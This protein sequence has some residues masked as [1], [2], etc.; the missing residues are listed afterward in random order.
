MSPT[1]H[2]L[3]ERHRLQKNEAETF[4]CARHGEHVAATICRRERVTRN[5]APEVNAL[6]H[7]QCLRH[8]FETRTVVAVTDDKEREIGDRTLEPGYGLDQ[9]IDALVTIGRDL[10]ANGQE[11]FAIR[12]PIS[13]RRLAVRRSG[14]GKFRVQCQRQETDALLSD[15][16]NGHEMPCGI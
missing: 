8:P 11:D 2:G 13:T 9:K 3:A 14:R 7:A 1:D 16:L 15:L 5:V 12:R 4:A 6:A 10:T